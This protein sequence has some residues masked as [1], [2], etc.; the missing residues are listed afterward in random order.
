MLVF[1]DELN[2]GSI[3]GANAGDLPCGLCRF[4]RDNLKSRFAAQIDDPVLRFDIESNGLQG[5]AAGQAIPN[6]VRNGLVLLFSQFIPKR[7]R[8][9]HLVYDSLYPVDLGGD[10][11]HSC[12]ILFSRDGTGQHGF[13]FIHFHFNFK[14][15]QLWI[16]HQRQFDGQV[17]R[18]DRLLVL[19]WFW[20]FCLFLVRFLLVRFLV[21][22][23]FFFS[24]LVLSLLV[25]SLLVLG[26]FFFSLLV[27][28]F[29]LVRFPVVRF[30]F[31]GSGLFRPGLSIA[32]GFELSL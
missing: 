28:C 25:L 26:L 20:F 1:C 21:F 24:L 7:R 14:G 8:H 22:S 5:F 15:K 18:C 13:A 16:G 19:L 4:E 31:L 29:F 3:D 2:T 9:V 17:Q 30:F 23:L 10:L 27:F 6:D 32:V 11:G 12:F